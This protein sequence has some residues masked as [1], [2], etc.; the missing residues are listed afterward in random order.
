MMPDDVRSIP[1][2]QA[3]ETLARA[4]GPD[5]ALLIRRAEE[6]L[7]A[8]RL[9]AVRPLL[10]ALD[11]LDA[12][13][14]QLALLQARFAVQEDRLHEAVAALDAAIDGTPDDPALRKARA[15]VRFRLK[16]LT[17]AAQD[18]AEAVILDQR[19]AQAK[20]QLGAILLALGRPADARRCLT[21]AL[22]AIPLSPAYRESLAAAEEMDGNPETAIATLEAGIALLPRAVSLRR[23]LV[24]IWL[25][26]GNA[27]TAAAV[28]AVSRRE[29]VMDS[30]LL[31]LTGHALIML[32]LE[33]AAMEAFAEAATLD[34]DDPTLRRITEARALGECRPADDPVRIRAQAEASASWDERQAVSRGYRVPG[35]MRA[36]L[37]RH[38][39]A[40][41]DTGPRGEVERIGP[42]LD[43]GCGSGLLA[44]AI[45]GL[46]IGTLIGV[47]LSP[48]ML[49][50]A[51][52]KSLYAE[53]HESEG[54]AFLAAERR[55]FAIILAAGVLPHMPDPAPLFTLAARCLLPDGV[56]VVSAERPR[57]DGEAP[58]TGG[59]FVHSADSIRCAAEAAMLRV[60]ALDGEVIRTERGAPVA[61]TVAVLACCGTRH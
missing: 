2:I 48:A 55:S 32:D 7:D 22:A 14:N 50:E 37:I 44:V 17:G 60:V 20:A 49:A 59:G 18:A 15:D 57:A 45:A 51:R 11:R 12:P 38:L 24:R 3:S 13:L 23:A 27:E 19:D 5:P 9:G 56:F 26:L 16:L 1:R 41:T 6:L 53:L 33:D 25:R 47:D 4:S 43:L 46:R 61:G 8:G 39:P 28:A 58:A 52:A 21:E 42:V 10:A 40:L 35:L 36:A 30:G 54:L 29:G 34:P 31:A